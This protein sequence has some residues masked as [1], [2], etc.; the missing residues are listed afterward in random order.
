MG[1]PPVLSR[2]QPPTRRSLRLVRVEDRR[3]IVSRASGSMSRALGT[4]NLETI[5]VADIDLPPGMPRFVNAATLK[6]MLRAATSDV[7]LKRSGRQWT[8]CEDDVRIDLLDDSAEFR[9]GAVQIW[10]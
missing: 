1:A 4:A 2:S 6:R 10:S 8:V 3:F 7:L 5:G 9:L